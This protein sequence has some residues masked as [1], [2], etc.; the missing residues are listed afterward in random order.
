MSP[1]HVSH[2]LSS[3]QTNQFLQ[4]DSVFKVYS[5]SST[6]LYSNSNFNWC[7][8]E[9]VAALLLPSIWQLRWHQPV[10]GWLSSYTATTVDPAVDRHKRHSFTS[11][12]LYPSNALWPQPMRGWLFILAYHVRKVIRRSSVRQRTWPADWLAI[13][14]PARGQTSTWS[15]A[16][17]AVNQQLD[18]VCPYTPVHG[19]CER[20][21]VTSIDNVR[22][23]SQTAFESSISQANVKRKSTLDRSSQVQDW[24]VSIRR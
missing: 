3:L 2:Q 8:V 19:H 4:I 7:S 9:Q 11:V 16:P 20:L 14:C 1:T 13:V 6:V 23:R 5:R 10:F 21:N 18:V 17:T 22:V 24:L 12:R 15:S